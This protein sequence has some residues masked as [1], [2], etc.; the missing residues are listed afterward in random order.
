M[1]AVRQRWRSIAAASLFT[2]ALAL[3]ACGDDTPR[4][5]SN[6]STL[7]TTTTSTTGEDTQDTR[8]PIDVEIPQKLDVVVGRI[9]LK[10]TANVHEAQVEWRLQSGS[11]ATA[12]KGYTT[13]TCGTGCRGT[14]DTTIR[15]DP[16]RVPPANYELYVFDRSMEDGSE[17]DVVYIPLTVHATED[18][19]DATPPIEDTP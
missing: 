10:G 6:S 9:R 12:M 1:S 17:Q 11:G 3:P 2:M 18:A 14:F 5:H 13:A 19:A 16:R 4:S 8:P 15:L 7:K